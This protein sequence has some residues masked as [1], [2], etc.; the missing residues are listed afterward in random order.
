MTVYILT[1]I[2]EQVSQEFNFEQQYK[3]FLNI[4]HILRTKKAMEKIC[5]QSLC[6]MRKAFYLMQH[7]KNTMHPIYV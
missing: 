3:L 5:F 1:V 6:S 7:N 4:S 2:G